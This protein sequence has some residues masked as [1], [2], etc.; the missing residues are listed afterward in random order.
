MNRRPLLWNKLFLALTIRLH[1]VKRRHLLPAPPRGSDRG[2]ESGEAPPPSPSVNTEKCVSAVTNLEMQWLTVWLWNTNNPRGVGLIKTVSPQRPHGSRRGT[3]ILLKQEEASSTGRTL[4]EMQVWDP[5][6]SLKI[7]TG[8][9]S[10][11]SPLM[12]CP[13][14]GWGFLLSG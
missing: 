12:T 8:H 1:S 2:S 3:R 5:P 9:S 14:C 13:S 10:A 4:V 7:V 6:V 11:R